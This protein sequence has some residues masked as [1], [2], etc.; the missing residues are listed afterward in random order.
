MPKSKRITSQWMIAVKTEQ[1]AYAI[2]WSPGLNA[3]VEECGDGQ[4]IKDFGVPL[5]P[6][7]IPVA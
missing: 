3:F 5:P 1:N 2:D 4:G 6:G 7:L